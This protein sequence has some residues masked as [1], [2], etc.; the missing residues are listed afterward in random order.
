MNIMQ[1]VKMYA[2][3]KTMYEYNATSQCIQLTQRCMNRMQH[4][5][6]YANYKTMYGY[7]AT[8]ENVYKLQNDVWI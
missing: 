4:V 7:N 1:Q 6:M 8:S 2:N 5:E 3:Y